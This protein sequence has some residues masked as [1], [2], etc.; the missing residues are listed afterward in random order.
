MKKGCLALV[1]LFVLG[2]LAFGEEQKEVDYLLFSPDSSNEF[3]DQDHART[4][5]D[6][7]ARYLNG[8]N[9]QSGEIAV[10]G[11]AAAANN[12]IDPLVLSRDRSI[13]VINELI[14][15]GVPSHLFAE[16][17]GHGEV[18][19]WGDNEDEADRSLNRRVRILANGSVVTPTIVVA[20]EP[21]EPP[22]PVVR[23]P[24]EAGKFPWALILLLL[25]L[26]ATLL[27]LLAKRKRKP[28]AET[29]PA[30]K[31]AT[32]GPAYSDNVLENRNLDDE[33]R[34]HAYE[35]WLWRNGENGD[36]YG[37]WCRSVHEVCARYE[38][39]GYFFH[40]ENGSWWARKYSKVSR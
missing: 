15:R 39:K 20:A 1:F 35:L 38:P 2:A 13:F 11:Y 21:V 40:T 30:V 6:R 32:P 5:L 16:A 28:V 9:L 10:Y 31:P 26:L 7:L 25:L 17:V 8:R 22:A 24:K 18:D 23:E 29:A 14:Q 12:D 3:V 27:F 33:I 37:D 19:T 34:F 36:A 4:Q